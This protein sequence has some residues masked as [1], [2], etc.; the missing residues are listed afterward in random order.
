MIE[1]FTSTA[2]LVTT[3]HKLSYSI[4]SDIKRVNKTEIFKKSFYGA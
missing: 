2:I 1:K 3:S 4:S